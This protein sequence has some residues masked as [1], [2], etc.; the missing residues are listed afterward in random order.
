MAINTAQLEARIVAFKAALKASSG[1]ALVEAVDE[2]TT[3]PAKERIPVADGIARDS[4]RTVGPIED[5]NT[6]TVVS[7]F[8]RDDDGSAGH[9]PS[10]Q[11]II[12]LHEDLSIQHATG[13]AKFLERTGLENAHLIG[14][15]VAAKMRGR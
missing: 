15:A 8:G 7:T 3:Q 1:A 14:P 11:Y 5:G 13:G 10:S 4:G 6:V 2:L 12:P 9:A